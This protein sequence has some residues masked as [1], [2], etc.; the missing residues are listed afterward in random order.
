MI[1]SLWSSA[2]GM[3]AYQAGIDVI[4]NNMSNINT[5]GYKQVDVTFADLIYQPSASTPNYSG[6]PINL[7]SGTRLAATTRQFTQGVF[8]QTSRDLD[9]AIQGN[10]FIPFRRPD[11]QVVYTRDGS[12]KV[13]ANGYLTS[14]NGYLLEPNIAVPQNAKNVQIQRNGIVNAVMPDNTTQQIG[15]IY[16]A[17]F[18]NPT[19][20]ENVGDNF[21]AASEN[22]GAVAV[23]AAGANGAGSVNQG[24]LERSNVD[25]AQQMVN[26]ITGQR[27][28]ELSSRAIKV[29]DDMLDLA[30]RL[31]R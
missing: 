30:N 8:E 20:L 12:L 13:D 17:N 6:N 19:G 3:H 15:R 14:S 7:G 23:Q 2:S 5:V 1:R 27:A 29:A 18:A 21:F 11:G 10:G 9:I 4:S 24:F 25:M 16:L 31:K 26:L 22:S 28:Y